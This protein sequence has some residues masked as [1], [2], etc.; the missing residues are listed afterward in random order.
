MVKKYKNH[1]GIY[2]C[3]EYNGEHAWHTTQFRS[4]TK[5]KTEIADAPDLIF[6]ATI[7]SRSEKNSATKR[8][9]RSPV[10]KYINN[11]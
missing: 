6:A 8:K 11:L 9:T 1:L 10:E 3:Y 4:S 5:R 7:E 2:F